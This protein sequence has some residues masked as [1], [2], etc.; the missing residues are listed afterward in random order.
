MD[1]FAQKL[2]DGQIQIIQTPLPAIGPG[3]VLV[4]N[5]Y[6]LVSAGTEGSTVRAARKSILGKV[7]ERPQQV[8]QVLEVLRS[9]G[10]V[11][12]YRSVM[13][14]LD[15]WSPL[16]YSCVGEVI[17]LGPEVEGFRIGDEVACGGLNACHAEVVAVPVNLCVRLPRT[18]G[19]EGEKGRRRE[20]EKVGEA[21]GKKERRKEDQRDWK[22]YLKCAA[23]NTLGAI[24]L[25][26]V[27]QADLRLGETCGVIGLGLLGQ[28][29]CLLMRGFWGSRGRS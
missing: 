13:K 14:K 16:G 9:Q 26:G 6:S 27:R 21:E 18:K 15:A 29:T 10:P 20:G 4:K 11:Q 23:Y 28:L 24:A 19:E 1:Q 7:R 22:S 8:K 25:Q 2:K 12:T 5:H 3:M 17:G